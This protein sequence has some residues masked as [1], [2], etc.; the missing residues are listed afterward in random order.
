VDDKPSDVVSRAF[1]WLSRRRVAVLAV[2]A[3]LLPI[4]VVVTTR[5]PHEG[6]ISQL[7]VPGDPDYIATQA[8]DRIFP[9]PELALLVVESDEPWS[10]QAV[11]RVDRT[12]A[13]LAHVPHVTALSPL[14]ALRRARPGA[15]TATL[16]ALANG[17]EFFRRHGLIG[18]RFMTVIATLDTHNTGERD[19]ALA[20]IHRALAAAGVAPVHEVG[21]PYVQSWL[22]HQ[23][24]SALGRSLGLVGG[25]FVVVTWFLFRSPRAVIAIGIAL[26]MSVVLA[27]AAGGALGFSFTIVSSLV[28]L[29]IMV[30]TLATLTYLHSRFVDQPTDTPLAEHQVRALRNKFLPV[31]ASTAAAA[32]GF[33]A[34]YVSKILPVREM[35]VWTAV[36]LVTAW[37]VA[38]TLFPA[39][40][41][42]LRTPTGRRVSVRH[43]V[44]DRVARVLPGRTL[45]WRRPILVG[46]IALCVASAVGVFGLPGVVRG[47]SVEVDALSNLDPDTDVARDLRWLREHVDGLEM[48]HVWIHLPTAAA[49]DPGVLRAVDRLTTEIEASPGVQ[50]VI[51][52]T[53]PLRLRN[54][55]AGNGE[56]LAA[57]LSDVEQLLLAETSLRG[58]IDLDGLADLQIDVQFSGRGAATYVAF[59]RRLG[60]LWPAIRDSAPS[61]AGARASLVGDELLRTK[62]GA[63]LVPTLVHSLALTIAL[64]L[65][66]F[67]LVFRSGTER[68][69]AMLP[70]LFAVLVAFLCLRLF[71]GS[72]DIA[73]VIVATIVVGATENDQ[74]HFFHHMH[75]RAGAPLDTRLGHT[76]AVSGRAIVF[77]TFI[78]VAGFLA[79]A[80]SSFPPLRRLGLVTAAAFLLAMVADFTIL[81]AALWIVA[82]ARGS[83]R[84]GEPSLGAPH[85]ARGRVARRPA[86]ASRAR[87]RAGGRARGP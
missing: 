56:T 64:I 4:A 34:L 66:V 77:A 73:T 60:V 74:L 32:A 9:E 48:A 26:G 21:A 86:R 11:A 27:L 35:G 22:E 43:T 52:P 25:L 37:V 1:T 14:D 8:F 44:Y 45:R 53:T 71:G 70:S 51:G 61:L 83:A 39:L 80:T 67:L 79:L 23:S 76:L 42:V 78:N 29:T 46:A 57:D 3:L 38:F 19:A 84:G 2:Y 65:I 41:L 15:D 68:I 12:I 47:M 72:L 62:A 36:G 7:V 17:T 69:L 85:P 33:G 18:D 58:F 30:T 50:A 6:G 75:E 24:S 31:T 13:A 87:P 82:R 5:I 54:Y 59:D 63:N 49:T 16:R 40:Q 55:L 10:E 81:P 28:P 20:A